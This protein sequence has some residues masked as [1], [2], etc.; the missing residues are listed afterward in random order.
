MKFLKQKKGIAGILAVAMLGI[1]A[2]GA[3]AYFTDSGTGTGSAT[4]G[5]SDPWSVHV[6]NTVPTPLFPGSAADSQTYEVTNDG[7]GNQLLNAVSI[8]IAEANGDPWDGNGT[9]SS[10]DFE[11]NS[12][13]PG[14]TDTTT[15]GSPSGAFAPNDGTG[16]VAFTVRMVET[17]ANQ[18]DCKNETPPILVTAS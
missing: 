4:V 14:A 18:D 15:Y 7:D 1:A 12:A 13:G 10:D 5:T 17:G 8:R 9:C 3:Y 2:V 11:I 16:P 6:A